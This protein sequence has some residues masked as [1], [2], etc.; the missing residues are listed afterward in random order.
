MRGDSGFIHRSATGPQQSVASL[1]EGQQ[2]QA[3]DENDRA[4][5]DYPSI[6]LDAGASLH[7]CEHGGEWCVWLNVEDSTFTGLCLSVRPTRDAAVAEAV[8]VLE[9]AVEALQR[10]DVL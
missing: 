7:V 8:T 1:P 3:M 4:T 9:Q 2:E 5:R 6:E 10:P